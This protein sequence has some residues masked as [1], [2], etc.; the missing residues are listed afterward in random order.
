MN[1]NTVKIVVDEVGLRFRARIVK[2]VT[3]TCMYNVSP[4]RFF[5]PKLIDVAVLPG[6]FGTYKSAYDTA[7]DMLD[8]TGIVFDIAQ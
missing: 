7:K 2:E 6:L 1:R 8:K 4:E 5:E 3:R